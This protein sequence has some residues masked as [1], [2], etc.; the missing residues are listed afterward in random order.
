[1]QK[2]HPNTQKSTRKKKKYLWLEHLCRVLWPTE[3]KFFPAHRHS[4]IKR[5]KKHYLNLKP[6]MFLMEHLYGK[7]KNPNFCNLKQP[8]FKKFN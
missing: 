4:P 1:M 3:G 2:I 8:A 6:Q 5:Q 7:E